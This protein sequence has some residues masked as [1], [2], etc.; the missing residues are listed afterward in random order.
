MEQLTLFDPFWTKRYRAV[1]ARAT[2][3]SLGIAREP[4]PAQLWATRRVVRLAWWTKRSGGELGRRDITADEH[5]KAADEVL[6]QGSVRHRALLMG[7]EL[8]PIARVTK[9]HGGWRDPD[10]E[11]SERERLDKK[12]AR[13][14]ALRLE[15]IARGLCTSCGNPKDRE[16]KTCKKCLGTDRDWR[17]DRAVREKTAEYLDEECQP[18]VLKGPARMLPVVGDRKDCRLE[19]ECL[20]ELIRACGRQDP[21]GASC[22]RECPSFAPRDRRAQLELHAMSRTGD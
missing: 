1:V 15:R 5:L 18:L 7:L 14:Q 12:K 17:K 21:Q 13:Q 4:S 16:G 8:P 3:N 11:L 20:N 2:A 19:D 10:H 6:V 22:P 9:G